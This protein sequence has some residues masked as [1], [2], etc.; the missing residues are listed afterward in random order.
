M[1]QPKEATQPRPLEVGYTPR[2]EKAVAEPDETPTVKPEHIC[3]IDGC[4]TIWADP[5]IMKR[6]RQRVHGIGLARTPATQ[7]SRVA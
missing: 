5:E 2:I 3:G 4:K 7:R 1:P 6:H